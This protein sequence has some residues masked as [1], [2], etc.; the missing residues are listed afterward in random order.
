MPMDGSEWLKTQ[1]T[2]FGCAACGQPY[3]SGRIRLLAEREGLFF[4]DLGCSHCGTQA[5]A[6][7]TIQADEDDEPHIEAGEHAS[8]TL[9]A[10][11]VADPVSADDVL[12]VHELLD[13][14]AGG[15]DELLERLDGGDTAGDQ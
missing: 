10:T 7:V 6:I 8:V 2:S 11:A 1:L 4:V 12:A 15:I 13:S 9:T 14:F 5:V 3:E